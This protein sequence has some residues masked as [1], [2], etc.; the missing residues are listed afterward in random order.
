MG[1]LDRVRSFGNRHDFPVLV[2]VDFGE[3]LWAL[4]VG[5]GEVDSLTTFADDVDHYI[6]PSRDLL[7]GRLAAVTSRNNRSEGAND[8][9]RFA[10]IC[11]SF[12]MTC[13]LLTQDV[14]LQDPFLQFVQSVK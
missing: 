8:K 4:R 10:D 13:L 12:R 1:V 7:A 3:V 14:D 6:E 11:Y 9:I 2:V 5:K